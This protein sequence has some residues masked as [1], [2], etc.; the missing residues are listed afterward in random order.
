VYEFGPRIF[1]AASQEGVRQRKRTKPP[2][3]ATKKAGRRRD[4]ATIGTEA[5]D[6][7]GIKGCR[8]SGS[9]AGQK[10]KRLPAKRSKDEKK[11]PSRKGDMKKKPGYERTRGRDSATR[12]VITSL[13]IW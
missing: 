2:E 12:K 6:Q 11:A 9:A 13:K 5:R 7:Q 10:G 1:T 3:I 4:V 8:E